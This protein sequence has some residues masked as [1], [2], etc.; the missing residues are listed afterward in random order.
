[1]IGLVDALLARRGEDC[2][3]LVEW[4][5]TGRKFK[6]GAYSVAIFRGEHP[7]E[8]A[9]AELGAECLSFTA[10]SVG[11][12]LKFGMTAEDIARVQGPRRPV[13][14]HLVCRLRRDGIDLATHYLIIFPPSA[15]VDAL[16]RI[17][18]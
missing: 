18:A 14:E 3:F 16:Q 1:M 6:T 17:T 11:A 4:R 8:P 10:T 7:D 13:I 12:N 5:L 15:D 2:P 9:M